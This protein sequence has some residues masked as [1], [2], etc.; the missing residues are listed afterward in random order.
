MSNESCA[1]EIHLNGEPHGVE[2]KSTVTTLL[3]ELEKD[4]R[5]VAIEM[6]GAIL[7]R[8]AYAETRLHAGDKLEIVQFVQ[9]G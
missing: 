3:D 2:N 4:P 7:P 8:D 6:N 1:I 9:G 5:T